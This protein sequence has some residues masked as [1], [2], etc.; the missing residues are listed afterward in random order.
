[1]IT[2]QT[3]QNSKKYQSLFRDATEALWASGS[4]EY[5]PEKDAISDL[6]QYFS[7]LKDLV[8]LKKNNPEKFKNRFIILPIDE[9]LFEID[10]NT[11]QI[12]VPASFKKTA[13]VAG[14]QVAEI[15]Y[16]SIDRYFDITDLNEQ[17]I[18]IEWIGPNGQEG[19]SEEIIRDLEIIPGKIIFGW[20]LHNEITKDPGTIE[21]DVCFWKR[22]KDDEPTSDIVYT[23]RTLPQRITISK[24][25]EMDALNSSVEMM[26]KSDQD[27]IFNRIVNSSVIGPAINKPDIPTILDMY[28]VADDNINNLVDIVDK[29][30][31]G[32]KENEVN[33]V[34]LVSSPDGKYKVYLTAYADGSGLTYRAYETNSPENSEY[35]NESNLNLVLTKDEYFDKNKWYYF[36][37]GVRVEATQYTDG[38]S[39]SEFLASNRGQG[40]DALYEKYFI[41]DLDNKEAG[42]YQIEIINNIGIEKN[43][44][45]TMK[46]NKAAP[47]DPTAKWITENSDYISIVFDEDAIDTDKKDLSLDQEIYKVF[48]EETTT[49]QWYKGRNKDTD[50]FELVEN[51]TNSTYE[52]LNE[53]LVNGEA[54]YHVKLAN[55]LNGWTKQGNRIRLYRVTQYPK[56]FDKDSMDITF[57]PYADGQN[58]IFL[59]QSF[60]FNMNQEKILSDGFKIKVQYTNAPNGE[61]VNLDVESSNTNTYS[62]TP[63]NAGY[64][65]FV[66]TNVLNGK[67]SDIYEPTGDSFYLVL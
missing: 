25:L 14:D 57:L 1:M 13:G 23:L 53:D 54:Y 59:G 18:Y 33:M 34:S 58:G 2:K 21:F 8:D 3:E 52:V 56:A 49:Y 65:K 51:A 16:F 35:I 45:F 38:E 12:E 43:S 17:N 42:N 11:R 63:L 5:D 36:E 31:V 24:A 66:I 55:H 27:F 22:E 64:Y 30:I 7:H 47:S 60:T 37:N 20:A 10:A 41:Y 62:Y 40:F 61:Y 26:T 67:E 46:L 15:V 19:V 44:Q 32:S 4:E 39:I 50:K 48:D 29:I 9:E 28:Y 6:S